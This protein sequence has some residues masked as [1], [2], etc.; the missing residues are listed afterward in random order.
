[1]F[2]AQSQAGIPSLTIRTGLDWFTNAHAR[3]LEGAIN[4]LC[5]LSHPRPAMETML[6]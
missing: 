2:V 6:G 5:G 3:Q 4:R 1:M